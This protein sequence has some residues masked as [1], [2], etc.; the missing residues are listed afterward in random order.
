MRPC[1]H[2][3]VSRALVVIWVPSLSECEPAVSKVPA[4]WWILNGLFLTCLVAGF[5][6]E[7]NGARHVA[8][9]L[10]WMWAAV[11]L[12]AVFFFER[13]VAQ[14]VEQGVGRRV[15]R[16]VL[17]GIAGFAC[18][19]FILNDAWITALAYLFSVLVADAC[20]SAATARLA[21]AD[22]TEQQPM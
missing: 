15:P 13:A 20:A 3:E 17:F 12:L 10:A 18:A 14:R 11:S 1:R 4:T 6:F 9:F 22:H 7:Q 21:K 2:L 8:V 5:A 16:S 19:T